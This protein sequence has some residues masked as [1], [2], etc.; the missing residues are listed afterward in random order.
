MK[1]LIFI[2]L[3]FA[4]GANAE[5]SLEF[6]KDRIEVGKPFEMR[7]VIPTRELAEPR[8]I[9]KLTTANGFIL[10][11]IDSTDTQLRDFFGR[12]TNVRKYNFKLVAPRQ[13]GRVQIGV[14]TWKIRETEYELSRPVVNIQ[15]SYDDAAVAANLIPSKKTVYEGEQFSVNLALHTYEHFQ[16][17][18][19]AVSMDLGNDFIA[20]RSDLANL[21]FVRSEKAPAEMDANAKFAWL[22]PVKSGDL[23]IPAFKFKYLKR[24]AP[25]I[26]EENKSQG[27]FS[28]SFKS[29][30]QEAEEAETSSAPVSIKV[31]PLP[32]TLRPAD[33]SG[34][35]GDYSFE[36]DFDRTALKVGEALTLNILIKGDGKPGTITDPKLPDFA[37]FRSVPPETEINKKVVGNKVITTKSIKVFL[38]PKKKG[39]FTIPKIT[40]NWFNPTQ[41]KY[42]SKTLGPWEITVEKGDDN[43]VAA[44]PISNGSPNVQ[45][46][47]IESLGNDIR[48]IHEVKDAVLTQKPMFRSFFFWFLFAFPIFIYFTFCTLVKRYRKNASNS[49]LVRKAKARKNLKIYTTQAQEALRKNDGKAFYAALEN[50][51]IGYLSD[52]S[53]LEFRGMIKTQFN[54]NLQDLGLT[55]MQITEVREW[56]ETCSFAR[57]APSVQTENERK[58]ALQKFE[59]L[60]ETLE[61]LK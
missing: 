9:P 26:V 4:I 42:Q 17:N 34:M 16:G 3:F 14:I 28:M 45:K 6:D 27:G 41:K 29:I 35:V 50:G 10:K 61:V 11:G 54:E 25:K 20:H 8:E 59:K 47:D 30:R 38:Y 15:K 58:E 57:F 60:C 36:G 2:L 49:A 32:S 5:I 46:E 37:D 52:L 55:D 40:Y 7:I 22:A 23:K 48:F 24:G 21:Q 44:L 39:S 53:N 56:L 33:F 31:L 13:T 18:L 43:V 19:N 12:G 1:R 51:L